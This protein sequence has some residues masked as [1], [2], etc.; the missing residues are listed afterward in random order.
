M[1]DF[2]RSAAILLACV[3]GAGVPVHGQ[4]AAAAAVPDSSTDPIACWWKTD[5][6][7]VLVGEQFLLTLTCSVL[8]S[9]DVHAVPDPKQFDVAALQVAPFEVIAATAHP[10]LQ[11]PPRRYFQHE[12]TVRLLKEGLF[13]QDV[14][15]PSM[16]VSYATEAAST[17]E[18]VGPPRSI[19][20]PA[21]PVRVLSIVPRAARGIRE[22]SSDSFGSPQRLLSQSRG[23]FMAAGIFFAFAAVFVGLA[24]RKVA[25][26]YRQ[27]AGKVERRL[28]NAAVMGG[29]LREVRR[30]EADTRGGWTDAHAARAVAALRIAAAVAMG[31]AVSQVAT[32]RGA[33][34]QTGQV[35]MRRGLLGRTRA[36][37]SAPTTPAATRRAL[38]AGSVADPVSR[39]ALEQIDQAMRAFTGALYSS[40]GS[41]DAAA[42]DAALESG[43][44]A[45]RR[46]RGR[47]MAFARLP[48]RART[49]EPGEGASLR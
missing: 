26:E 15:I 43:A 42:L 41:L 45:M 19:V 36:L 11:F 31:R 28:S 2:A 30:I 10:E 46:L 12:Y 23:A 22:T 47:A 4:T 13:G 18:A 3:V 48:F 35:A 14:D 39:L 32:G 27:R 40:G 7:A 1:R 16:R 21:L 9:G 6:D 33:E 17:G 20:L 44:T 37:V 24:V 34:P 49:A 25:G 8:E 38:D 5:K 29:C